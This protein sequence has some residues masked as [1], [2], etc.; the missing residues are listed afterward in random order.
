MGKKNDTVKPVT[1]VPEVPASAAITATPAPAIPAPGTKPAATAVVTAAPVPLASAATTNGDGAAKKPA[2][3]KKAA[4]KVVRAK[5]VKF[6][7]EDIALRAYFIAEHRH[8]HGLHGDEHSDWIEAER[9][10][11][12][13]HRK[14]TAK[15]P[16]TKKKRA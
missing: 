10:L 16:A 8:Q 5:P 4:K 1:T 13:E 3:K 11:K 9:Q 15:K 6:L 7:T 2:A 14:A 12:A